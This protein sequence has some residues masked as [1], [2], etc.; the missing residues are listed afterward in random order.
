MRISIAIFCFLISNT[1]ST[2]LG[3]SDSGIP[4]FSI[5]LDLPPRQRFK[6][7]SVHMKVKALNYFNHMLNL[8]DPVIEQI[9]RNSYKLMQ[10]TNP[11]FYEETL[12]ISEALE[13]DIFVT[14]A[15]SFF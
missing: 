2:Y 1:L 4:I 10:I 15:I 6:E 13:T 8:L 14:Q 3:L 5:D 7:T 9:I 11:E 12:G